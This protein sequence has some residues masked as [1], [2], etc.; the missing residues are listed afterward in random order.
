MN[1]TEDQFAVFIL[2]HG[3]PDKV[4]TYSTIRRQH[5]TGKV[6]IIIDNEDPTGDDYRKIYGNQ[7]IMF[8][9]A[10]IAATFDECDNF[11][12]SRKSVVYARNACFD[13][14]RS[15]G[16]TYFL[17]LDD[18]YGP[19]Q[20]RFSPDLKP[21][22]YQA[23]NLDQLF[24]LTL[25]YY[26]SIPALTIAYAQGGD[27]LGGADGNESKSLHLKRKAMNTFFCSTE[28]PFKF[29]GRINED[30]NMYTSLGYRGEIVFTVFNASIVQT[31]TQGQ[32]GGMTEIYLDHGTYIKSFYTVMNCPSFVT[33]AAMGETVRR[34]HHH[35]N[36]KCGVPVI[37]SEQYRKIE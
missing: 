7:V 12:I 29:V 31:P 35:I 26:K 5:Y 27:M 9:K 2:S 1:R 22:Y 23:R 4:K 10:A 19:F 11:N 21:A 14:A 25:A 36:W 24:D 16:I 33:I 8:D 28:R 6:Y 18:D 32:S 17:Q 3:R 15:L 34:L 13:I 37:M 30:V 20:Y